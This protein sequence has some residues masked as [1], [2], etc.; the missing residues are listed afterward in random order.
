MPNKFIQF[1]WS[2]CEKYEI[3]K[4]KAWRY[5]V[6]KKQNF[7]ISIIVVLKHINGFLLSKKK[8]TPGEKK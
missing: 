7:I 8:S 2:K 6:F 5:A 4:A 3:C 1:Y